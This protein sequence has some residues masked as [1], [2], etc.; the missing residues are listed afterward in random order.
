[1]KALTGLDGA[2][3]RDSSS[4][5]VV[6]K[7]FF[8]LANTF[9]FLLLYYTV[10]HERNMEKV[11]ALLVLRLKKYLKQFSSQGKNVK[12]HIDGI[13]VVIVNVALPSPGH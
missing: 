5:A 13:S 10:V 1:M 11:L 8:L 3:C 7:V 12:V 6:S 9:P 2:R 4:S